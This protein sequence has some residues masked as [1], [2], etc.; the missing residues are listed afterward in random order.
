[1]FIPLHGHIGVKVRP[2]RYK[3][4]TT[5]TT[6][7]SVTH[8]IWPDCLATLLDVLIWLHVCVNVW[9]EYR[10]QHA[11][12]RCLR[13]ALSSWVL[14]VSTM[15][16]QRHAAAKLHYYNSLSQSRLISFVHRHATWTTQCGCE[17]LTHPWTNFKSTHKIN[18]L[19]CRVHLIMPNG[20]QRSH[21]PSPK[22]PWS[23]ETSGSVL[24]R[25]SITMFWLIWIYPLWTVTLVVCQHSGQS[26]L[27]H[28]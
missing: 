5:S 1:M 3:H 10:R 12:R 26:T 24:S 8:H 2:L 18:A 20:V 19:E 14:K 13:W 27:A 17:F 16:L 6:A 4:S 28:L 23:P 9:I 15:K 11:E 22:V 25:V 21:N 7:A